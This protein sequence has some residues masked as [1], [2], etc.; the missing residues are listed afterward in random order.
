[1][2]QIVRHAAPGEIFAL[3]QASKLPKASG[4][5]AARAASAEPPSVVCHNLTYTSETGAGGLSGTASQEPRVPSPPSSFDSHH[6]VCEG[7]AM[8]GTALLF[9][10]LERTSNETK[11]VGFLERWRNFGKLSDQFGGLAPQAFVHELLG[12]S[13]QRVHQLVDNGHLEQVDFMGTKWISARSLTDWMNTPMTGGGSGSGRHQRPSKWNRLVF[14]A[15]TV[16]AELGAKI[17]E[18]WV[19]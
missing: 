1:M 17:P 11:R 18:D 10:E 15:K 12:C 13:R 16:L 4:P 2:T 19:E 6:G 8:N 3:V 5:A 14:D 7:S 9:P